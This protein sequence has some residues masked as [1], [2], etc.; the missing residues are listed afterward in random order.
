ML[1]T[2]GVTLSLNRASIANNSYVDVS[3]IGEGDEAL[4]CHTNK[5]DC[6]GARPNRAGEW[7]YPNII[8]VRTKEPFHDEFYRNRGTQ[9]VRLN[10]QQGTFTEILRGRFR[11]EVPDADN[12]TQSIYAYIGMLILW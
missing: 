12:N 3:D 2:A 10:R 8:Q 4:L 1:A 6:C 7:Y 5:P 9:V 11:C